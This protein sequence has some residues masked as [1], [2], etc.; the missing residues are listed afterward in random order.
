MSETPEILPPEDHSVVLKSN[1]WQSPKWRDA[2][3]VILPLSAA[4]CLTLVLWGINQFLALR[5][6]V[7]VL[8]SRIVLAGTVLAAI[9]ALLC[10]TRFFGRKRNLWLGISVVV[11]VLLGFWLDWWAPKPREGPPP[12]QLVEGPLQKKPDTVTAIPATPKGPT[13]KKIRQAIGDLIQQGTRIRDRAPVYVGDAPP[14]ITSEWK[15]WT[16]KTEG[17]LKGNFDSAEVQKFRSLD[18]PNQ[19]LNSKLHYEIGYLEQLLD[20]IGL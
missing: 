8:A 5:G 14:D 15:A 2:R 20:R 9:A 17:F 12:G 13:K 3:R 19:S 4:G 18:D 16:A 6:V 1:W 7:H 11:V 10:I